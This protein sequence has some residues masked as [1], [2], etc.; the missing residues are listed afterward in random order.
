M[1]VAV[2]TVI[3]IV[4]WSSLHGCLCDC[5]SCPL[6]LFPC[7]WSSPILPVISSS[8]LAHHPACRGCLHHGHHPSVV[9]HSCI[10][11]PIPIPILIPWSPL[12]L[13][14]LSLLVLFSLLF[15]PLP[16]H[17]GALS[18]SLME[19]AHSSG[20]LVDGCWWWS[21]S[22]VP[23]YLSS[24]LGQVVPAIGSHPGISLS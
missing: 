20:G 24:S 13:S 10:P 3:I 23:C 22:S 14:F 9:L 2:V 17:C 18:P 21:S 1:V 5:C 16:C 8:L 11:I 7:C 12:S 19:P 4:H 15:S 6:L